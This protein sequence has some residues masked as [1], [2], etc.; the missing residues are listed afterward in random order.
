MALGYLGL[1]LNEY[2]G[3]S[4]SAF[5]N[6]LD[7]FENRK[8]EQLLY[9]R[10]WAYYSIVPHVKNIKK[11]TDL[12]K[13]EWEKDKPRELTDREVELERKMDGKR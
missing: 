13:F 8:R 10:L 11:P 4:L 12:I 9:D 5:F 6:K 3:I 1:T 7:G 2:E